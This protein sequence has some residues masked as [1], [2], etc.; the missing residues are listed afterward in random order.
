MSAKGSGTSGKGGS[1]SFS[2]GG[3][4]VDMGGSN[5]RESAIGEAQEKACADLVLNIVKRKDRLE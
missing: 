5:F 3:T 4:G 2:K 1:F